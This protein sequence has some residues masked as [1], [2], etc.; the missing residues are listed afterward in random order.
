MTGST[1]PPN[2]GAHGALPGRGRAREIEPAKL[3][4]KVGWARGLVDTLGSQN[5]SLARIA[6]NVGKR[7]VLPT[8]F[9]PGAFPPSG[10]CY[11]L[12]SYEVKRQ[13][14]FA[15]AARARK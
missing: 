14:R 8:T 6:E 1:S 13:Q 5:K 2:E 10:A 3:H 9:L 15:K 4:E 7:N 11:E 12:I